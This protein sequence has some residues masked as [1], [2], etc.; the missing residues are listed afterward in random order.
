MPDDTDLKRYAQAV[1]IMGKMRTA[2]FEAWDDLDTPGA[3]APHTVKAMM[4]ALADHLFA[5]M[6]EAKG[7]SNLLRHIGFNQKGD[8]KDIFSYDLPTIEE[9][10][11]RWAE[12]GSDKP[13]QKFGFEDLL[14]KLIVQKSLPLYR[15]HHY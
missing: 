12:G 3:E 8:Y 6:P 5:V 1:A 2:A 7:H 9:A 14:H 4:S 15:D 11:V 13:E 10:L